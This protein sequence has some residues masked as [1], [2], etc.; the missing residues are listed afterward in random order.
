MTET[1]HLQRDPSRLLLVG[2]DPQ[3]LA[4][5]EPCIKALGYEPV[6]TMHA[7]EAITTCRSHAIGLAIVD[8]GLPDMCGLELGR[9]LYGTYHVPVIYLSGHNESAFIDKATSEDAGVHLLK[10]LDKERIEAALCKARERAGLPEQQGHMKRALV[11]ERQISICVGVIMERYHLDSQQAYALLRNHARSQRRKL[12]DVATAMVASMD[13]M[14]QLTPVL[15][16][17]TC[18]GEKSRRVKSRSL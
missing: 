18:N 15:N 16:K 1:Q 6:R 14:N 13:E 8:T 10:P 2:V 17:D 9:L 3:S 5:L 4:I 11:E 7:G 12:V